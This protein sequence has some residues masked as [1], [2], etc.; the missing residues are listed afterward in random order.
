MRKTKM[1]TVNEKDITVKEMR[2]RDWKTLY[3]TLNDKGRI[4]VT[5]DDFKEYL[6]LFSETNF[7]GFG[8]E[9]FLDLAPSEAEEILS[10]WQEVNAAFLGRIDTL[11]IK[12]IAEGVMGIIQSAIVKDFARLFVSLSGMDTAKRGNTDGS[13]PKLH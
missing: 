3:D 11:G 13:S 4:K 2:N 10:A 12:K 6:K 1:I 5:I 8:Y 9:D 7:V